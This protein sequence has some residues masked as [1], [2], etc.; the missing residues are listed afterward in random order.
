MI[1]TTNM[2]LDDLK[3]DKSL[4]RRRI[5]DRILERCVPICVNSENIRIVKQN[6]TIG[7]VKKYFR[8]EDA[9][10]EARKNRMMQYAKIHRT[11]LENI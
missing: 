9:N 11:L 5:Y 3:E 4:S 10:E 1:I 7:N 6:E 2:E 8:E